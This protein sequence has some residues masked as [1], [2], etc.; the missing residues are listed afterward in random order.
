MFHDRLAL[1]NLVNREYLT[2][3]FEKLL[4]WRIYEPSHLAETP[5]IDLNGES[6]C[7]SMKAPCNIKTLPDRTPKSPS[8]PISTTTSISIKAPSGSPATCTVERAGLCPAKA[9]S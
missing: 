8:H 2:S 9:A 7:G 3:K 5:R 4:I 6:L 1:H